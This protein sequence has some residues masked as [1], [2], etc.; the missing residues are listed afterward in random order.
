MACRRKSGT[1]KDCLLLMSHP[2]YFKLPFL[3]TLYSPQ[4]IGSFPAIVFAPSTFSTLSNSHTS[5]C[6]ESYGQGREAGVIS[7][8][9]AHDE[10]C[11]RRL[12]Q[13]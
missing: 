6:F 8:D 13:V 1:L 5:I 3:F 12:L 10:D 11:H 7:E 9:V 2:N 4:I